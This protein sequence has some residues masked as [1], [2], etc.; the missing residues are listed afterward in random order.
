MNSDQ[1][2]VK[3][4]PTGCYLAEQTPLDQCYES[5]E[6]QVAGSKANQLPAVGDD[7]DIVKAII[8][9]VILTIVYILI[10]KVRK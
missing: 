3:L 4:E 5:T 7:I 8:I 10:K 6:Q 9:T 2:G 1:Q